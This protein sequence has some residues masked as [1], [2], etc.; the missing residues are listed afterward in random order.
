MGYLKDT[1]AGEWKEH[2]DPSKRSGPSFPVFSS[3]SKKCGAPRNR[4][5]GIPS[6]YRNVSLIRF[7][8]FDHNTRNYRGSV[9]K[10]E[11]ITRRKTSS[12]LSLPTAS[13]E[14]HGGR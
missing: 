13:M 9:G 12:Q 10:M 3:V 7:R 1:N 8:F 4:F 5:L 14:P 6:S 11:L 2:P